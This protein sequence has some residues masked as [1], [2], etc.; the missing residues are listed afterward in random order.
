MGDRSLRRDCF[1]GRLDAVLY[2]A[3]ETLDLQTPRDAHTAFGVIR[4][5][6][7]RPAQLPSFRLVTTMYPIRHNINI[8]PLASIIRKPHIRTR[9]VFQEYGH[10][11][12]IV[13]RGSVRQAVDLAV[14]MRE[15]DEQVMEHLAQVLR[16]R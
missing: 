8:P 13:Q 5:G 15:E 3:P 16:G 6:D 12:G 7:D 14:G 4:L 11:D 10:G 2:Q 1:L 9:Y